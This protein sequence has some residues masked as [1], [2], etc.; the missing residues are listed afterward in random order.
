[1]CFF[2]LKQRVIGFRLY[3]I[4]SPS[5]FVIEIFGTN[6]E[7]KLTYTYG[8][9]RCKVTV[10]TGTGGKFRWRVEG[11]RIHN[12]LQ[13]RFQ[14][15]YYKP[16]VYHVL[17][18]FSTFLYELHKSGSRSSLCVTKT[19]GRGPFL[20]PVHWNGLTF[21]SPFILDRTVGI[22]VILLILAIST[23]T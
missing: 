1:M 22:W 10:N 4:V 11:L 2:F 16:K 20:D 6:K 12:R 13:W 23:S 5:C 8:S 17:H 15:V 7:L 21:L 9:S 19:C 14:P 18:S 3:Y